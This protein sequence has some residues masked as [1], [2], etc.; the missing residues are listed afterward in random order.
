MTKPR[1][2]GAMR[3]GF[4]AGRRQRLEI[5]LPVAI[6]HHRDGEMKPSDD[7]TAELVGSA[8]SM[9]GGGDCLLDLLST[10]DE[11]KSR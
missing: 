9:D 7:N 2:P 5:C 4:S 3:R 11:S 1:V 8:L 10:G 6:Y